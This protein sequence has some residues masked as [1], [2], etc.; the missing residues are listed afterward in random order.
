MQPADLNEARAQRLGARHERL[1]AEDA[2]YRAAMPLEAMTL[3]KKDPAV[4]M[5]QLMA[6][7]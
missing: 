6:G 5:A 4:R 7:M 3:A 2:Q 1:M